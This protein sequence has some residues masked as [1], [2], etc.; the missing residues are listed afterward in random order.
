VLVL[1]QK[2]APGLDVCCTGIISTECFDSFAINSEVILNRVNSVSFFSPSVRCLRLQTQKV[3]AY[4]VDRL[5]FDQAI[6]SKAQSKGASYF[7]SS[8]VTDIA[9]GKTQVEVQTLCHG[10]KETLAAR[11]VILAN[12]FK[13][14]LS[15]KLGLGKIKHFFIGAQVELEIAHLDE[16]EVYFSQQIAPGFFAWL[17]PISP[18]KALA[19]LLATSHAKLQLAKF[20]ASPFCQDRVIKQRT[21]V[22]QKVMPL[23]TLSRT[24]GDRIVAIGDAAGQVKPTTGGGIYFGYLGAK[25]ASEVLGKALSYDDLSATR[26]S[27]YQRQWKARMGKEIS[28]GYRARQIYTRL[29][30]RQIERIFGILDSQG[31]AEALL[32]SPDSS[33]DW[34]SGLIMAGL[35]HGLSRSLSKTRHLFP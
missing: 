10:L 7:F 2:E 9:I 12:G 5:S 35:K 3:Q 19:G 28:L 15:R 23:G 11:A 4:V 32:N 26:L 1:E 33:F 29:D 18:S 14:G 25:I 24:Y 30:D 22:S 13:P 27:H 16:A 34:H 8:R 21:K 31:I 20:L 17:V 6:A